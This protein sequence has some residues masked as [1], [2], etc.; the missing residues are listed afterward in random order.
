CDPILVAKGKTADDCYKNGK[1]ST[2]D[3]NKDRAGFTSEFGLRWE[4]ESDLLKELSSLLTT[5]LGQSPPTASGTS[6]TP[7]PRG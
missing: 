7:P 4:D 2:S 6:T 1:G 3:Q 5:S